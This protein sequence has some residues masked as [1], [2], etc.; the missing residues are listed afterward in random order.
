MGRKANETCDNTIAQYIQS[1]FKKQA[2][3]TS[4]LLL[5]ISFLV[6]SASIKFSTDRYVRGICQEVS[7]S[8]RILVE[9]SRV[10]FYESYFN[11]VVSKL[12][13]QIAIEDLQ[14]VSKIPPAGWDH[15]PLGTC[16]IDW[17]PNFKVAFY[18]PS[19]WA[20]EPMYVRGIVTPRFIRTDLIVFIFLV[21]MVLFFSYFY[22]TRVLLRKVQTNISGPIYDVWQGLRT[23]AKPTILE[24][25]EIKDLWESLVE[26]KQLLMIRNRMLLAKEYYHEVKSPA[27]YQYNQLK[28]LTITDDPLKQKKIIDETLSRADELISQMEKA[29][30]K[31]ATDDYARYP[32]NFDFSLLVKQKDSK[33]QCSEPINISGDK[34]LIKT[35]LHNLYSNAVEACGDMKH[36]ETKLDGNTH[37]T[38]LSIRN[39]VRP[40]ITID[41]S[42]IFVSGFTT[43]SNGTGLGLSLCRH[44]VDL[45]YGQISAE[46]SSENRIFEITVKFPKEREMLDATA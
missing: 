24:I 33:F 45:H 43:R 40:D 34:T 15:Y 6:F 4:L 39:P 17:Q 28:R 22:G 29:L 12:K 7:E 23:G 44:I 5:I 31:I 13:N 30:K 10:A 32:K 18:S 21:C 46:F 14:V 16:T 27:F 38:V 3:L 1:Q 25:K 26:Y 8:A 11:D 42:M 9:T 41:T 19:H 20:G 36:V 37:E 35:L 2:K